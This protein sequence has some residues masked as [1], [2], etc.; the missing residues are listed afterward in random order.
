[1]AYKGP[2]AV[3]MAAL[4]A[5]FDKRSGWIRVGCGGGYCGP[6]PGHVFCRG[7]IFG[8]TVW[9]QAILDNQGAAPRRILLGVRDHE[10]AMGVPDML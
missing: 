4:P 10:A 2:A 9:P 8:M 7:M 6:P 3:E 1:M 5:G